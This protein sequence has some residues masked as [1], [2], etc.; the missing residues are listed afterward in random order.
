MA[1]LTAADAKGLFE[2]LSNWGRW[3][4]DDERGALNTITPAKRSA[5]AG[6]VREGIAVSCARD[7]ATTP[8]PEYT[9]PTQH[10]IVQGGDAPSTLAPEPLVITSDYFAISPHG[11]ATTH[12]DALCHVSVAGKIFNG[13]DVTE[14]KTTGAWRDSIMSGCDGIV[15][16]GVL[17]DL[18]ATLGI[19]YVEPGK[20]VHRATVEE[21]EKRSGVTVESGDVLLIATGRD[22]SRA[23]NPGA[24][25]RNA[26]LAGLH[27]DCLDWL[28][29][30]DIAV[31]GCDGISDVMPW[32]VEG[33]MLPIHQIA[34]AGMGVHLIDN[35][36]LSQLLAAC[37]ERNRYAFHL[38]V[39]PLRLVRGT[40]SPV[41]P[42]ALF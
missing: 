8:H 18:P 29:E 33:W 20:A 21:A 5:A 25:V 19:P 24:H 35:M 2:R 6:L 40:A 9:T 23:A 41:N 37:H 30:R 38:T 36:D 17:L 12:L 28:R 3:G 22:A 34:L 15:S 14:V 10:Y 11:F 31:L 13:F 42:I 32:T 1:E 4:K 7:L 26:G 39:A 16:R 27:P